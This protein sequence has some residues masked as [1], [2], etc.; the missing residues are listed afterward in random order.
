MCRKK[1]D[2]NIMGKYLT[3]VSFRLALFSLPQFK[4]ELI[5]VFTK[6]FPYA[7]KF[8]ERII[9]EEE[10]QV[11][12]IDAVAYDLEIPL[13]DIMNKKTYIFR[14]VM[15]GQKKSIVYINPHY[16]FIRTLLGEGEMIDRNYLAKLNCILNPEILTKNSPRKFYCLT[17]H[18]CE[19]PIEKIGEVM[20]LE[21][22]PKIDWDNYGGGNYV[23]NY[24]NE[25]C[26]IDLKRI[27]ERYEDENMPYAIIHILSSAYID[28][29]DINAMTETCHAMYEHSLTEVARCFKL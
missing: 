26:S 25:C 14:D 27:M 6:N 17:T 28:T 15:I 5:E 24:V 29:F 12:D 21:A 8:E 11:I 4:E 16:V 1:Y 18:Y 3:E 7:T 19:L 23:D 10:Q 20:D 22:F 2:N 9:T 13:I